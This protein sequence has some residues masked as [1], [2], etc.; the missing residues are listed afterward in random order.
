MIKALLRNNNN[1]GSVEFPDSDE[2]IKSFLMFNLHSDAGSIRRPVFVESIEYPSQLSFI[3]GKEVNL[4]EL[5]YLAK[6]IDSFTESEMNQYYAALQ[7]EGFRN[8][9][10]LINLTFNLD[11]YTLITDVSSP[12]VI[13]REYVLNTSG[14][15]PADHSKDEEYIAIG[16]EIIS[17]KRGQLTEYGLMIIEDKPIEQLYDG[18][19][20]PLYDYYGS[21]LFIGIEYDGKMEGVSLSENPGSVQTAIERLGAQSI[22]ECT[23]SIIGRSSEL[24]PIMDRLNGILENEGLDPLAAVCQ[25]VDRIKDET[26]KLNAVADYAGVY[27]SANL[28]KLI[29]HLDKFIYIDNAIEEDD[30]GHYFVDEY[31]N[32][33]TYCVSPELEEYVDF[34]AFGEHMMEEYSGKFIEGGVVCLYSDLDIHLLDRLELEDECQNRGGMNYD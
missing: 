19:I 4:D 9:R 13:G 23:V 30:V 33:Q 22:D 1:T 24:D 20:F 2:N 15:I 6:R 34:H 17:G 28:T 31:D 8:L 7:H 27:S 21:L 16:K 5:N 26:T 32:G 18:K 25:K 12:L 11:K 3:G 29:D 10:S 14:A